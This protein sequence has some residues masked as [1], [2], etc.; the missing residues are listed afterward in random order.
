MEGTM[1]VRFIG[2]GKVAT[3]LATAVAGSGHE[4]SFAVRDTEGP[5]ATG[6]LAAVPDA[7][8]VPIVG[9]AQG[10]EVLVL[11]TPAYVASDVLAT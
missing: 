11:A 8:V 6:A 1:H 3:A 9:C 5:S 4:V 10:A 7:H 2:S